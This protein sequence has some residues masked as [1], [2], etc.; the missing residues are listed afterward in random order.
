MIVYNGSS[1]E[2]D[3]IKSFKDDIK[4]HFDNNMVKEVTVFS[5]D[6]STV[7]TELDSLM[8]NIV[9]SSNSDEI[10]VTNLLS[11]LESKLVYFNITA[12]GL[13]EWTAY[14][15]I[16][17]NYLFDLDFTYHS[18]FF[19]D[20]ENEQTKD[21][22][23]TYRILFSTEP[24][25][26]SKYGFNYCMLGFDI[27]NY[28]I[29]GFSRYGKAFANSLSC[30]KNTSIT[31]PFDFRKVSESGGYCNFY[32]QSI[33]YDKSYTIERTKVAIK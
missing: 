8:N 24:I 28:F 17:I 7:K 15:G 25:K 18:P 5:N 29:N 33:R 11:A 20:Y 30:V 16:D 26:T 6:F 10:F 21:F 1:A 4:K 23:K 9:L 14:K 32:L 12:I 19:V 27:C 13:M 2:N 22:L 3:Q 31:A